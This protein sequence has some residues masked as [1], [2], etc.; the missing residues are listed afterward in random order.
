MIIATAEAAFVA[1]RTAVSMLCAFE[2][3]AIQSF[4]GTE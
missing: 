1:L 2:R 4:L 3:T